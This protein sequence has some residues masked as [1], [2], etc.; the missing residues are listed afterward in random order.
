MVLCGFALVGFFLLKEKAGLIKKLGTEEIEAEQ[1]LEEERKLQ[2]SESKSGSDG[3]PATDTYT[4]GHRLPKLVFAGIGISVMLLAVHQAWP[5]LRLL[6]VGEP[7]EAVAVSIRATNPGEP[8]NAMS[9]QAELDAKT[10]A[11]ANAKDYHWTFFDEFRFETKQGNSFTFLREDGCKLKPAIPLLDG[12]GLPSTVRIFY[13]PQ[14]PKNVVLPFEYSTWFIPALIG[15]FGFIAFLVGATPRVVRRKTDP[16]G[17]GRAAGY[18]FRFLNVF[19]SSQVEG[20]RMCNGSA[21]LPHS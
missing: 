17:T 2:A 1:A 21:A 14:Q 10:K 11:V 4:P 8:D 19:P 5:G 3:M 20:T 18:F 9:T 12:N 15:L 13:D 7:A 6:V 16:A